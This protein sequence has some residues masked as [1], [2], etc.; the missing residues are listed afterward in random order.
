MCKGSIVH[1]QDIKSMQETWIATLVMH[2]A[3]KHKH[4]FQ[5][6]PVLILTCLQDPQAWRWS[7]PGGEICASLH[8][9]LLAKE[10]VKDQYQSI[11][12]KGVTKQR[13]HFRDLP[14]M[15]K[16]KLFPSLCK[17]TSMVLVRTPEGV[18]TKRKEELTKLF[19]KYCQYNGFLKGLILVSD[20]EMLN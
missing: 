8:G 6:T 12:T 1:S 16:P 15:T 4:W 13:K 14:L 5:Q 20:S 11:N 10:R 18:W 17:H 3:R 9:S 19:N 2:R 7:P